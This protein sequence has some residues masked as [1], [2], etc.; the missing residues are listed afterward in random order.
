MADGGDTLLPLKASYINL[1]LQP[2]FVSWFLLSLKFIEIL[3][4]IFKLGNKNNIF[5]TQ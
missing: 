3:F 4:S 1:N 2:R 5:I